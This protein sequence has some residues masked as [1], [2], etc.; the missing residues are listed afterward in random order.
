MH[1][2]VKREDYH[3]HSDTLKENFRK[4]WL[5]VRKKEQESNAREDKDYYA[6][7]K[8]WITYWGEQ[9]GKL[10]KEKKAYD[11]FFQ[12]Y[13]RMAW[14]TALDKIGDVNKPI[15]GQG[16]GFNYLLNWVLS[17]NS[18]LKAESL[19]ARG[20]DVTLVDRFIDPVK[21]QLVERT[22]LFYFC[23]RNIQPTKILS[24][25]LQKADPNKYSTS[26]YM[27]GR[28]LPLHYAIDNEEEEMVK[29]LLAYNADPNKKKIYESDGKYSEYLPLHLAIYRNNEAIIKL[30]LDHGA[31]PL[32]TDSSGFNAV[33]YAGSKH[34][35]R[36]IVALLK[37]HQL[38]QKSS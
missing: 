34:R 4:I 29:L 24:T 2:T 32:L 23:A 22:A 28:V 18:Q 10:R 19:L 6:N 8:S 7:L 21:G 9:I 3:Y 36:N 25:L 13:T 17:W 27:N 1:E 38:Q 5:G 31:D 30:L 16:K 14:N 35:F 20:A 33:E 37:N 26:Y 15:P 12:A 11:D